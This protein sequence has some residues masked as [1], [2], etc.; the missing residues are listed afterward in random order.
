MVDHLVYVLIYLID[1]VL[2]I[3][4]ESSSHG[5]GEGIQHWMALISIS[6]VMV[7]HA[8]KILFSHAPAGISRYPAW[9]TPQMLRRPLRPSIAAMA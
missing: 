6:A 3:E 8:G 9:Y 2:G 4:Y 7:Y 1:L 5:I